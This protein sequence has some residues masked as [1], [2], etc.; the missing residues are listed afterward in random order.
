MSEIITQHWLSY[1]LVHFV[2]SFLG[3]FIELINQRYLQVKDFVWSIMFGPLYF[4]Q[5]VWGMD[6]IV[7]DLRNKK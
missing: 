3:L 4:G 1:F 5:A 2:F 7:I 6:K